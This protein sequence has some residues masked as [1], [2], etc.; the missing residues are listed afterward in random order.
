MFNIQCE[1]L[2]MLIFFNTKL[3]MLYKLLSAGVALWVIL[4]KLLGK[5][6]VQGRSAA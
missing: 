4:D 1:D 3:I 2:M 6:T 5:I